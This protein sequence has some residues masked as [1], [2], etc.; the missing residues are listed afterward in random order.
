MQLAVWFLRG[1]PVA[2]DLHLARELLRDAVRIGHVDAALMEIALTANGSG[3]SS[4]W[5]KAVDLLEVAA[6]NDPVA[7]EQQRLIRAMDLDDFGA[8]DRVT[9][10]EQIGKDPNVFRF[11][12]LLTESEC[13]HI[14]R[15]AADLLEPAEVV[16][17]DTGKFVPH[18]VR[19]SHSGAIGPAREDLVVRAINHRIAAATGT[20]T[21]QGEP[22]T[23]LHYGLGQQYRPH[24][25]TI[26]KTTNQR[27][28]TMLVYLNEG[29]RGGETEFIS[30]GLK[31]KGRVGDA[32][33]FDNVTSEGLA[34]LRSKHAGL[35]IISGT[36]WL[37]TRWI[38]ADA[39]DPWASS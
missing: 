26:A 31:V 5:C 16:D 10:S 2:R 23:V 25:D 37:A 19:T 38:R 33:V 6:R 3:G 21:A 35:P 22:L 32:I 27:I 34:D 9:E 30:S 12:A 28:K 7:S 39:Y 18:P 24:V 36:K 1:E 8:P 4:D 15:V 29:Y 20:A 11:A 14:A 17:P 13:A